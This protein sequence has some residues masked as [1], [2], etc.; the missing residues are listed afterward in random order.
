M[1]NNTGVITKVSCYKLNL[2]GQFTKK[3]FFFSFLIDKIDNVWLPNRLEFF[4][5]FPKTTTGKIK[6]YC[7]MEEVYNL[8]RQPSLADSND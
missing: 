7:L 5:D 4:D 2:L 1:W 8:S 6:T 3:N